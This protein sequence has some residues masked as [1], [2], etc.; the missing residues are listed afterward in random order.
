M[1]LQPEQRRLDTPPQQ[2][3]AYRRDID[4]A[5]ARADEVG[6]Q[7]NWSSIAPML[8]AAGRGIGAG[9]DP[10]G[11]QQNFDF[12]GNSPGSVSARGIR[13]GV[14]GTLDYL[15]NTAAA[16]GANVRRGV[17]ALAGAGLDYM[18]NEFSDVDN[19]AGAIESQF[20]AGPQP[21]PRPPELLRA[22]PPDLLRAPAPAPGPDVPQYTAPATMP[23]VQSAVDR[24]TGQPTVTPGNAGVPT[25]GAGQPAPSGAPGVDTPGAPSRAPA[26]AGQP[27]NVYSDAATPQYSAQR[28]VAPTQSQTQAPAQ[29]QAPVPAGQSGNVYSDSATP[30]YSASST[31]ANG[32]PQG[33]G[34]VNFT[35]AG[36]GGFGVGG[37]LRQ[38]G[39]E[40]VAAFLEARDNYAGMNG[41]NSTLGE[42][43]RALNVL[44]AM[45]QQAGVEQQAQA[46]MY[47]DDVGGQSR[48][49]VADI[50]RDSSLG[51]TA[52][53]QMGGMDR[54][55]IGDRT[56]RRA[57]DMD[58]EIGMINAGANQTNAQTNANSGQPSDF[59]RAVESVSL[60]L[61]QSGDL[62]L[63]AATTIASGEALEPDRIIFNDMGAPV[64]MNTANGVEGMTPQMATLLHAM[65]A[66]N[67][68]QLAR[69][70]NLY[71]SAGQ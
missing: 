45:G 55:L 56:T 7:Q 10:V 62:S 13:D 6:R 25:A 20:N 43:G 52:L 28:S 48:L 51:S 29:A 63:P 14:S 38:P 54:T 17:G 12:G 46:S 58:Y 68:D 1:A 3:T 59:Q 71:Q 64:A 57:N 41:N 35:P 22:P 67:D 26:S 16:G 33:G 60:Q 44:R 21:T 49:G 11:Q 36:G 19:A 18:R 69:M 70:N 42:R 31:A 47:G 4:A 40:L 53:Q 34:T 27:S 15:Q 30:Q 5:Y 50:N 23:A 32:I 24:L 39:G 65:G 37:G 2:R 66:L 8:Q 61:F 9:A